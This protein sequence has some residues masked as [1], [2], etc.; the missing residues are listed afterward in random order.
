M[1]WDKLR[2][3]HVVAQAGSFTHAGERLNL[4]QSA[5]SRQISNF[6]TELG[7]QLFSRHA[8]GLV[9]T[10]EG[11]MLQ[12]TAASVF[13]QISATQSKLLESQNEP[14]GELKVACSI[15]VG[16]TWFSKR[17]KLFSEC[18]PGIRL[19][20]VLTDAEVDFSMREADIAIWYGHIKQPG[21][22]RI[23]LRH[24]NLQMYAS[25]EYLADYGTPKKV[26]DLDLHKLI[27]YGTHMQ[28]PY[29][30]VN[31]ILKLGE[32]TGQLRE[33]YLAV[34][35]A[36]AILHA[37]QNGVGIGSLPFFMA[38]DHSDLVPILPEYKG[39]AFDFYLVYPEQMEGSKKIKA[40]QDFASEH[41]V[42]GGHL[43]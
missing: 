32:Q 8:R 3:F 7:V 26:E 4:S 9:L 12:R 25:K 34:N 13:T 21:L 40:F 23:F 18:Y 43:D 5:V 31:W 11:D 30:G 17:L 14:M 39:P 28:P 10:A 15:G 42:N 6:E 20:L 38:D 41:M 33:P 22:K 24:D 16:T 1:D 19:T 36:P 37:I 35:N 27:V 29:E 2:I